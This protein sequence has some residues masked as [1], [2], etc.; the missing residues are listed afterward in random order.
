MCRAKTARGE[1]YNF[2]SEYFGDSWDG[3][4]T[5]IG[6]KPNK[7]LSRRV[8]DTCQLSRL[9]DGVWWRHG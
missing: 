8:F 4:G 9:I 5:E 3:K 1:I 6:N 7:V 2:V